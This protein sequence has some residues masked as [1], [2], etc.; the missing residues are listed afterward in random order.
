[1][2]RCARSTLKTPMPIFQLGSLYQDAARLDD[3]IAA[4]DRAIELAKQQGDLTTA[5]LARFHNGLVFKQRFNEEDAEAAF[6]AAAG[7]FEMLSDDYN[8]ALVYLNLG[9]L[10]NDESGNAPFDVNNITPSEEYFGAALNIGY[11]L[12][13]PK[14]VADANVA[15]GDIWFRRSNRFL[16]IELYSRALGYYEWMNELERI[17][18]TR[19]SLG[20]VALSL[21]DIERAKSDFSTA[22]QIFSDLRMPLQIAAIRAQ[23]AIVYAIEENHDGA[24]REMAEVQTVLDGAGM[25]D[26]AEIEELARSVCTP[27]ATRDIPTNDVLRADRGETRDLADAS[28]SVGMFDLFQELPTQETAVDFETLFGDS[29]GTGDDDSQQ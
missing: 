10:Y 22:L 13:D 24:C 14:L 27:P 23:F 16:A 21:N 29:A 17:A 18:Q 19:A 9:S 7:E 2:K 15:L 26:V 11:E 3:A 6:I 8:R 12:R 4:N 20:I 28:Q 5:A 1:M 25:K